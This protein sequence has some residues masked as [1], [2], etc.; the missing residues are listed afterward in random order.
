MTVD[1]DLTS[2]QTLKKIFFFSF[3]QENMERLVVKL[4]YLALALTQLL[5]GFSVHEQLLQ[6]LVKANKQ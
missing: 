2:P 5:A 6:R 3:K 4:C 1:S